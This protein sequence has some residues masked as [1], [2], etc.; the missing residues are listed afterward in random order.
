MDSLPVALFV[1]GFYARL[2]NDLDP[3]REDLSSC[4][5]IV[6]D[7]APVHCSVPERQLFTMVVL[8]E[9]ARAQS[10]YP[11]SRKDAERA[12]ALAATHSDC[13]TQAA[14][15]MDMG[16]YAIWHRQRSDIQTALLGL[17]EL[18]CQMMAPHIYNCCYYLNRS[19][20]E[21]E[22]RPNIQ[23]K[24]ALVSP[25]ERLSKREVEVLQL[26]AEGCSN[27]QIASR[28]FVTPGTVK[29]H[30]EHIYSKLH[31]HSR[32]AALARARMHG[33]LE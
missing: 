27:R 23:P 31:A 7:Y 1:R 2:T 9:L 12:L 33:L 15:L 18:A 11:Q 19:L 14:L 25:L 32:T 6:S 8:C 13:Y 20:S 21:M 16:L 4:L 17:H 29:K 5:R 22:D 24:L 26:V 30:L 28:L 3:A 10:D